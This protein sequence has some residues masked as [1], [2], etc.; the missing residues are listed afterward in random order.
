[1]VEFHKC[2]AK[3]NLTIVRHL[4]MRASLKIITQLRE[5]NSYLGH[6]NANLDTLCAITTTILFLLDNH[7]HT[8]A[9]GN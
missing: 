9:E 1:M 4:V 8:R 3:W 6:Q 7:I 5:L 2:N